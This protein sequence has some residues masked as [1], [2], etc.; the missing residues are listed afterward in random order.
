M[1]RWRSERW[2]LRRGGVPA[3]DR[4][5][6]A[7]RGV[8]AL[9]EHPRHPRALFWV[10]ELGIAGI[11]I[12]RQRRLALQPMTG[13]LEGRQDIVGAES[14]LFGGRIRKALG[15]GDVGLA[16]VLDLR[17]QVG[18]LPDRH[19]VLTPVQAKGPSR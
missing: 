10:G 3:L 17:D 5:H 15:I 11:D 6:K 16:R 4:E 8:E 14:E 12:G 18:V 7:S 1:P 19:A 9:I 13:V 2:Q